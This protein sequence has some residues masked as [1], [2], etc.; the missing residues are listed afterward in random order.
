MTGEEK[1]DGGVLRMRFQVI[2]DAFPSY[3]LAPPGLNP[4]TARDRR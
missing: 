1:G 4:Y 2:L 3:S